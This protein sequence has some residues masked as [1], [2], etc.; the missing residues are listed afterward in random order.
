M[1]DANPFVRV[2]SEKNYRG[3]SVLMLVAGVSVSSAIPLVTLFLTDVLG[4]G[5]SAAGL[6]FLTSLGA[7]LINLYT[8]A[9]SDRMESRVPLVRGIA[10][11]LALGWA[12]MGLS[13]NPALA[14][15]VG[16][17]FITFIGALNAQIFAVLRDVVERNGERREASVMST[18]RTGY[19][20]GW[21]LGPVLGSLVAGWA[22]YR[23]AFA[24]TATLF[25]SALIPLAGLRVRRARQ[26][27][28]DRRGT[29]LARP[30]EMPGVRLGVFGLVCLLV[31]S[32]ETVR[33]AYLPI[34]ATDR[35][36]M[37]L[38]QFGTLMA[39]APL[40]ELAAMPLAGMLADRV[41]LSRV[42][43]AGFALGACGYL[44]F[45]GGGSAWS[46]YLGQVLHA[47]MIAVVFGLGVTY[48]QRLSPGS[49]GLAGSVFFSAQSLSALT[50]SL[51]GSGGVWL[52]GL[53]GMFF[54]PA[55]VLAVA[56]ALFVWN[57]RARRKDV[58]Q[59]DTNDER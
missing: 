11:W 47:C 36:G 1:T 14:F 18:V 38:G 35:L 6:F 58:A 30:R 25:L 28:E 56:C 55:A 15:A 31:L 41:G 33:L 37:G 34:F 42:L 26:G 57:D 54:M 51:L 8:G 12:L 39:L 5:E 59:R 29:G 9:L 40:T 17:A 20:F 23:V 43:V 27:R 2:W 4:V 45:G 13:P 21:T 48:A 16:V 3:L 24:L 52:V 32:G 44:L 19:S 10:I 53:P 46:L 49:A 50:G 22:G 7:P